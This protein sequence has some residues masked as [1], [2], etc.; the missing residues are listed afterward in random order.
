LQRLLTEPAAKE[1]VRELGKGIFETKHAPHNFLEYFREKA[2][3]MFSVGHTGIA[4]LQSA[5]RL[6]LGAKALR[7]IE[8]KRESGRASNLFDRNAINAVGQADTLSAFCFS[9]LQCKILFKPIY[10]GEKL[11]AATLEVCLHLWG[12]GS[13]SRETLKRKARIK[14]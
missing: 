7:I 12:E 11:L 1:R 6:T 14:G 10:T 13:L 4:C 2:V 9:A 5:C 8:T 3:A